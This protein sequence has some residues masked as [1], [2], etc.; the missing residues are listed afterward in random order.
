MLMI[1][2]K[3]QLKP[4]NYR[5]IC[6]RKKQKVLP[7]TSLTL[8]VF[9][10]WKSCLK[11]S[12]NVTSSRRQ[13]FVTETCRRNC[14]TTQSWRN[15][16]SERF[17]MKDNENSRGAIRPAVTL[18]LQLCSGVNY[19]HHRIIPPTRFLFKDVFITASLQSTSERRL[20]RLFP[21]NYYKHIQ[22]CVILHFY[23]YAF[24]NNSRKFSRL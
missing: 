9:F 5:Q 14:W 10:R 3:T 16:V 13:N 7:S 1:L 24:D 6:F 20:L 19:I 11:N 23:D 21:Q 12:N 15:K 4:R 2:I 18:L 17:V 8:E 22:Y